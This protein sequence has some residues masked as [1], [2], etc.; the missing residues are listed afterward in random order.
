M[1]TQAIIGISDQVYQYAPNVSYPALYSVSPA[2]LSVAVTYTDSSGNTTT[3]SPSEIGNY[4]VHVSVTTPGYTGSA[5]ALL[6]ISI[7]TILAKKRPIAHTD[8]SETMILRNYRAILE[9]VQYLLSEGK[10]GSLD[11]AKQLLAA[12]VNQNF[13]KQNMNSPHNKRV[14]NFR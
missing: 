2:N 9:T 3:T 8:D 14:V 5:S 12:Q 10:N 13:F 1:S 11:S 7:V 4:T 6:T